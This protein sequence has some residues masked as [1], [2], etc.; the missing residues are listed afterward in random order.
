MVLGKTGE[1]S[2]V[3]KGRG[4]DDGGREK[5]KKKGSDYECERRRQYKKDRGIKDNMERKRVKVR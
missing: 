3:E 5:R 2:S 4:K 1:D